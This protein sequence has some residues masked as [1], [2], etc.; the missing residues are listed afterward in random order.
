MC[1]I[2]KR[3]KISNSQIESFLQKFGTIFEEFTADGISSLL[4]YPLFAAKRIS[5]ILTIFF[6]ADPVIQLLVSII[7]TLCVTPMQMI[8]YLFE[9]SPF[10]DKTSE[11]S[12]LAGEIC[13]ISFYVV[14]SIPF[15]SSM[16]LSSRKQGSLCIVIILVNIGINAFFNTLSA[17]LVICRWIKQRKG[18][19]VISVLPQEIHTDT[20]N[21]FSHGEINNIKD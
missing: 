6:I 18:N 4:F 13:V 1:L 3:S 9:V 5:I 11:K 14:F 17:A 20:H 19:R 12:L 2:L 7:F 16:N 15:I 8:F 21:F 10:I